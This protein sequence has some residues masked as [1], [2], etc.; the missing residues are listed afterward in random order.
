MF[1]TFDKIVSCDAE[2]CKAKVNVRGVNKTAVMN[3]IGST[4]WEYQGLSQYCCPSC[5]KK[6]NKVLRSI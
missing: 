3:E 5:A 2:G 6:S 1:N 4:G